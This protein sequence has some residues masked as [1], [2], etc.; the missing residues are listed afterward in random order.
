VGSTCKWHL[1]STLFFSLLSRSSPL[2]SS[3]TPFSLTVPTSRTRRHLEPRPCL[4]RRLYRCA[5]EASNTARSSSASRGSAASAASSSPCSLTASMGASASSSLSHVS[6]VDPP[7]LILG[8]PAQE[9]VVEAPEPVRLLA[10]LHRRQ[11]LPRSIAYHRHCP[12]PIGCRLREI[13]GACSSAETPLLP[14]RPPRQ[15]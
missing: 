5:L 13:A 7:L 2:S 8:S 10:V 15:A 11:V 14:H 9:H 4:A 6:S 1:F 3:P 12:L